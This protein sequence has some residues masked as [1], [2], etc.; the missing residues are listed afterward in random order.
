MALVELA[1]AGFDDRRRTSAP[2][3]PGPVQISYT[4]V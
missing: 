4:E 2:I 1:G 3:E